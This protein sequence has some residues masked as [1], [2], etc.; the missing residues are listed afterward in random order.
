MNLADLVGKQVLVFFSATAR[1]F[2]P[3]ID[4]N[5][6]VPMAVRGPQGEESL[7][8]LPFLMGE[9]V[10]VGESSY[11]IQYAESEMPGAPPGSTRKFLTVLNQES[12]AA[13]TF[14]VEPKVTLIGN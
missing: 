11:A 3:R 6:I 14:Y 5:R 10:K 4:S 8:P 12:I 1:A 7:V 13:I 2:A 9:I